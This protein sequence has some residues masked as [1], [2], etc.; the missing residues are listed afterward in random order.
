MGVPQQ[1]NPP[2]RVVIERLIPGHDRYSAKSTEGGRIGLQAVIICDGHDTVKADVLFKHESETQWQRVR[3][4]SLPN[5][6]YWADI[7]T[8]KRGRY[9]YT[10]EAGIDRYASWK[11][12]FLKKIKAGEFSPVDLQSGEAYL[13]NHSAVREAFARRDVLRVEQLLHLNDSDHD[14]LAEDPSLVRYEREFSIQVDPVHAI[15]GSWYEF[16]PRSKWQ[17]LAPAG[18][19][20]DSMQR[21][22][23]VA[24]LG[25]DIV[26]LPPIHPIGEAFRKGRNNSLSAENDDVGSPWAIGAQAGGHK[27]IHPVLGNFDD[28][29]A[30]VKK[31]RTLDLKLAL[32]IALQC[33]P[34]HPYVRHHPEW[35]AKRADGSIQYAENPPKKYQDIYPFDFECAEWQALWRELKSI[36]IFWIEKGVRVFRVDNPHT[37]SFRFWEWCI[38]EIRREHNDV[39]FLAEAFTRPEVMGY[40][41]KIGFS[42]SYTYFAWKHTKPDLIAYMTDLTTTDMAHYFRPNFWPNTPDILTD[43]LQSG[44]RVVFM[45][46]LIL[47][48][49]L[50]ASYGIYGPAYE[51]MEHDPARPG[52]EEYL[53]SE[54]YQLRTWDVAQGKSLAPL[55]QRINHIRRDHPA[56][57]RND[58]L[59]FQPVEN[60]QLLAYTKSDEGS[61]DLILTVV[62]LDRT[63]TQSGIVDL[64]VHELGL[65][66]DRPY[67][68]QD[69]LTGYRYEWRGWRNY[70]ELNPLM[71]PAHIFKI[72]QS[73]R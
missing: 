62:N 63:Y 58:T 70:V 7:P 53:D 37:K 44:N 30:L 23:Y 72:E 26:Y 52:S 39:V 42:Q 56:L 35:F 13:R 55:I 65:A 61:G 28:F 29:A 67:H 60:S 16:F 51:L 3:M 17:H 34:D 1:K 64:Q 25:F 41:A 45:Q 10:V 12:A 69:L 19:L 6:R 50:S 4:S 46:R 27:S 49:T 15:F 31:A 48:A 18:T 66:S 57:H 38:D 59:R 14:D 5:D 47:A 11:K 43:E 54:K 73:D 24:G 9:L 22:E 71:L 32:D 21:L 36:F 2:S 8:A 20:K 68:L 40:L 33:S